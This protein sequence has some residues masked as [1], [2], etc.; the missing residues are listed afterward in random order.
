MQCRWRASGNDGF[1][2]LTIW[3]ARDVAAAIHGPHRFETGTADEHQ[4]VITNH[5]VRRVIELARVEHA[6][7]RKQRAMELD[8]HRVDA[9]IDIADALRA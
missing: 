3:P 2:A 9:R 6:Y 5:I 4:L 8:L 1:I 7:H